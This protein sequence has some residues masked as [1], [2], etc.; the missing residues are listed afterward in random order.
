MHLTLPLAASLATLAVAVPQLDR[1]YWNSNWNAMYFEQAGG[2]V[3]SEYVWDMGVIT[4]TLSGDTLRG[5]WREYNNAQTCGPSGQWSGAVL[6]LFAP[7]GKSFTG[8]WDYC[9]SDPAL[10][11]PLGS[12]W[13]G[14]LR[15]SAYTQADCEAGGRHW[16]Q[17]ACQIAP[18][19][20]S[21]TE[22]Q[23]LA[24]G[25]FWCSDV[26]SLYPCATAIRPRARAFPGRSLAWDGPTVDVL[27]RCLDPAA[28]RPQLF[29]LPSR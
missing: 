11:D 15:D 2:Q 7:D 29:F 3:A 24:V 20:E 22:S 27:G 10:L 25:H 1:T 21:T 17:N 6:F 4:G 28:R 5:W 14:T 8:S 16:C 18:C 13:V 26:C 19:G 12:S 23:C 9:G